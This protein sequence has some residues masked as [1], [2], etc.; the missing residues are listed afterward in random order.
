MKFNKNQLEAINYTGSNVLVAASAGG[1]KTTVLI[2][3]LL[4]RIINDK[5]SL[6]KIIAMTFTNAAAANMKNRLAKALKERIATADGEKKAYL[7]NELAKLPNARISTIHSFCLDLVKEYY[8]LLGISYNTTQNIIDE[9]SLKLVKD[10]ILNELIAEYLEK[11]EALI[12][13][14]SKAISSETFSFDT[15][16]KAILALYNEANAALDPLAFFEK[17]HYEKVDSLTDYDQKLLNDYLKL[18]RSHLKVIIADY[19]E[20]AAFKNSDS[21]FYKDIATELE[22]LLMIE[23][24]PYLLSKLEEALK[25]GKGD[26][27]LIGFNELRSETKTAIDELCRILLKP[28]HIIKYHNDTVAFK[29]TLLTLSKELYLR[30]QKDKKANEWIDFGDFEHYAYQILTKDDHK[31]AK[32][33]QKHYHEIMIDEFQDTNDTQYTIASLIAKDNLFLVGDIKQSIYRFRGA[34]PEIM[35]RLLKDPSF[36]IIH[37]QNN[38]RSKANLVALNNALFDKTMNILKDSFHK[39]DAQIA[40]LD[41]QKKD[42]VKVEFDLF[43]YDKKEEDQK[44]DEYYQAMLLIERIMKLIKRGKAFKDITVLVR[45][46]SE[47]IMIKKLFDDY[48]IPYF[49]KDNDGYFNSYAIEVILSYIKYLLDPN[50]RIALY[51]VLTSTLYNCS[52]D[53]LIDFDITENQKFK[54]DVTVLKEYLTKNIFDEFF[55][56]LLK[57]NAFYLKLDKKEKSNIDLLLTNLNNYQ[58]TTFNKL[59]DFIESTMADQ[60]ESAVLED[61]KADVV[62]VMT[63]HN[64]KGLEFDTV[65]LYSSNRNQF[66]EAKE[67][68]SFSD[69]YGI[70]LKYAFGPY[71]QSAKT[72]EV[73]L[74]NENSDLDDIA[75]YQRLLYVALT[76]A[77]NDLY[78]VD[79]FKEDTF[80]GDL[81]MAMARKGFSS[82]LLAYDLDEYLKVNKYTELPLVSKLQNVRKETKEPLYK[83]YEVKT[84]DEISPSSLED[85]P[86]TLD[87]DNKKGKEIGTMMHEVM[88]RLDLFDPDKEKILA[89]HQL[90]DRSVNNILAIF[91]D[92]IFKKALSGNIKREYSFYFKDEDRIVHGFIDFIAFLKDEIIIID[93]KSDAVRDETILIDRYKP[94][95]KTYQKVIG[96]IFGL[97][98]ETYIYSFHLHKMI[99]I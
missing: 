8:Y 87:L 81:R 60:K 15:L 47:K 23:D 17:W 48:G 62:N 32:L 59:A 6:D 76:R 18:I 44:T 54:D 12:L 25:L 94:Q 95:L 89:I 98:P 97:P 42:L 24:Y 3:R 68:L 49:I 20:L 83:A 72:L 88:E 26:K 91:E 9:A 79:A 78:I 67:T 74:I 57:I 70:G 43:S 11:D 22:D 53:D 40:D 63:I 52:N 21:S 30:L 55:I 61:E 45:T 35:E 58:M 36:K 13:D 99:R 19:E 92:P 7:E 27:E 38:Y 56:Y 41:I 4:K 34:K 51:S 90:D 66:N 31:V 28:S 80:R 86:L 64:S 1:G 37:I 69:Q 82:Y 46:H 14:L 96:E 16:K 84:F 71:R 75:E 29:N 73:I 5:I 50:D 93:Y 2:N 33:Y 65:I 77:K 10:R 39:E 85:H